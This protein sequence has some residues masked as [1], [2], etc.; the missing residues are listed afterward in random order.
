MPLDQGRKRTFIMPHGEPTEQF[1]I[2]QPSQRSRAEEG[3]QL[4]GDV[5]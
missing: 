2:R 5:R 4:P 3:M 1:L